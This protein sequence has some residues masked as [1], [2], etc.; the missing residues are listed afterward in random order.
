MKYVSTRDRSKGYQSAR[1]IAEGIAADGGLYT[2]EKLP[3]FPEGFLESLL[4]LSYAERAAKVLALYLDDFSE[5]ELLQSARPFLLSG[6]I[7]R[8]A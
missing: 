1:A 7:Y 2:P 5:E 8:Q 3:Q 4:P 6:R